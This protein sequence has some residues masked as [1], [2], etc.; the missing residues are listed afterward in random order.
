MNHYE[1]RLLELG[2]LERDIPEFHAVPFIPAP[3][4]RF[5]FNGELSA[6]ERRMM[7]QG[8]FDGPASWEE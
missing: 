1:A 7:E 5:V 4:F 6:D 2:A 8:T 3:P